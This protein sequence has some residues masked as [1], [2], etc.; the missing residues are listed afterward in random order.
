M[1][2]EVT[3]DFDPRSDGMQDALEMIA[4]QEEIESPKKTI[5]DTMKM[6][7]TIG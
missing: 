5:D 3:T 7:G 2:D 6:L 1:E 4:E